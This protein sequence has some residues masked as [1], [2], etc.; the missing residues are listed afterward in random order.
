MSN[1]RA[2]T[3]Q[4]ACGN[5]GGGFALLG[6]SQPKEQRHHLR[7]ILVPGCT[8][9]SLLQLFSGSGRSG[10]AAYPLPLSA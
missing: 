5:P 8:Q 6:R 9:I 3:C 2:S 1:R 7:L 4:V 10:S